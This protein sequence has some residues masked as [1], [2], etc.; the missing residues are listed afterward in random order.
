MKKTNIN[1]NDWEVPEL[2]P[3]AVLRPPRRRPPAN[4]CIPQKKI[5]LPIDVDL[6]A[7]FKGE[8]E[9]GGLNHHDHI[10]KALRQYI[11]DLV[12]DKPVSLP[13]HKRQNPEAQQLIDETLAEKGFAQAATY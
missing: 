7:W 10:N 5:T 8:A 4:A 12:G 2:P 1:R 13:R 9:N 6:I 3:N 11:I